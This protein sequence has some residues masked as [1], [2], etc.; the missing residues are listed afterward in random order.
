MIWHLDIDNKNVHFQVNEVSSI[1]EDPVRDPFFSE[2]QID[3]LRSQKDDDLARYKMD[4]DK[5]F[6]HLGEDF[7][8][9]LTF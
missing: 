6:I 9:E 8:Q 4:I 3:N 2:P 1:P 5:R 7:E